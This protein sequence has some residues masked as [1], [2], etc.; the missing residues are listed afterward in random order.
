MCDAVASIWVNFRIMKRED[1]KK[2][3]SHTS[4]AHTHTYIYTEPIKAINMYH[5]NRMMWLK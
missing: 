5:F 3:K 2:K 4:R 1:R